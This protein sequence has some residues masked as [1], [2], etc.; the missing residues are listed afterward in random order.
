MK[1]PLSH[2]I[3]FYLLPCLLVICQSCVVQQL[4]QAPYKHTT[5]YRQTVDALQQQPHVNAAGDTLQVGWAKVNITP[6]AG[7]PLAGYGK[8]LGMKYT[9]VH[10]SVWVRTFAF[11]NG[12]NQAYFVALDML[13]APMSVAAALEEEYPRLNLQPDQVYLSATHTHSSFGGWGKKVAGRIMAGKY[14]KEVVNQTVQRIIQSIQ[15]A[16]QNQQPAK[17]GYGTANGAALVKNRLTGVAAERDTT[18]RYLKFERSDGT[19]AILCS[20]SA[21]ATILPSMQPVLSGDYPAV[22]VRELEQHVSFAAFS[23]G[24]VGSHSSVYHHGDSFESTEEVG[25]NLAKRILA[26]V[27]E[28][29]V[30]FTS[31]LSTKRV[32]LCLP[33]PHW[34]I[35]ENKRFAPG[36][37]YTFFGRYNAYLNSLQIGPVVM[38]GVPAD[39]SGEFIPALA[40]HARKQQKHVMVTG[41]NGSY[42]GYIIPDA[43]YK[44]KKYEARAMNFYGPTAGSYITEILHRLL[45]LHQS[46]AP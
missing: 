5:Y 29:P 2:T 40:A 46:K 41:F 19:T 34:R 14:K 12:K 38:L 42:L 25:Q 4:D 13:I 3:L 33:E 43:H 11:D 22:L 16:R 17:V 10:D 26:A 24:A 8:R 20:F 28:T 45:S 39:Y 15:L 44:L 31:D 27:P 30:S 21:H 18:L 32:P 6:P 23:A 9:V 35:G 7:T 1:Q 37:F 36:L